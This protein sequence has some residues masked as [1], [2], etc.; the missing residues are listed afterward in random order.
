MARRSKKQVVDAGKM[1]SEKYEPSA[2]V[3]QEF[4]EAA[5]L[6]SSGRKLSRK[7]WRRYSKSVEEI[8]EAMG[9]TYADDEPLGVDEKLRQRDL[10]RW[11]LDPAS[12][13]DFY[14]RNDANRARL[15]LSSER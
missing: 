5:Q 3:K 10:H 11:E 13:E 8:G 15:R 4:A 12:S 9:L 2:E 14:D 6:A 1:E 7:L